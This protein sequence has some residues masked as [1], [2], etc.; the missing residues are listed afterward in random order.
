MICINPF[1]D[2]S[3]RYVETIEKVRRKEEGGAE[4]RG[5]SCVGMRAKVRRPGAAGRSEYGRRYADGAKPDRRLGTKVCRRGAASG[6]ECGRRGAD[7]TK[8]DRGVGRESAQAWGGWEVGIRAKVR[9]R[10]KAGSWGW[11]QKCADVARLMRGNASKGVQTGRGSCVGMRTKVCRHGAAS[12][13]EC[14]RRCADGA[15]PDRAV[16]RESGFG[17]ARDAHR[18]PSELIGTNR[19]LSEG[20]GSLRICSDR[21]R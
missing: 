21:L 12:G 7:G 9:R 5:G 11:A 15:K 17:C 18:N 1:N 2:L 14:G 6:S 20:L 8:P 10:G 3:N 19:N 16:G 4:R 13:S